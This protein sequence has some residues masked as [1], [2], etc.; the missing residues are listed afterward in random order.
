MVNLKISVFSVSSVAIIK[1]KIS[2][3]GKI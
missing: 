2:V 1:R 3:A